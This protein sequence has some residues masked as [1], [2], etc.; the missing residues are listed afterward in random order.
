MPLLERSKFQHPEPQPAGPWLISTPFSSS[1]QVQPP[2]SFVCLGT[3][4]DW[5]SKC[6]EIT[7]ESEPEDANLAIKD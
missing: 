7:K 5:I 4:T 1:T 3:I 2:H 6:V